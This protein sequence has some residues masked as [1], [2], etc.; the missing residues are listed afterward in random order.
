MDTIKNILDKIIEVFCIGIMGIMT[1]LV[2]WQVFTRYFFNKP[3]AIT[4][5]L[6]Q[7]LFV[8]LI[9]YGAAYV[10]GKRDH[11]KITFIRDKMENKIGLFFDLTQEIVIALFALS[12]MIYGGFLS[13]IRQ[14]VQLDAALQ[15]PIGVVYS[16]IPISGICIVF[17][18]IHNITNIYKNKV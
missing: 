7:Y 4:E 14:M 18:S 6:S 13:T 12:V 2:S 5:Q 3:S 1:L 9:L 11:M 10:F 16:A 15:I 17:Y 8:W